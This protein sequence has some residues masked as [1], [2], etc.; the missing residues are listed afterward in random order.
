M[1][2]DD[3][4]AYVPGHFVT[5]DGLRLYTRDYQANGRAAQGVPVI[6]LAGL[7]RNSRDFQQFALMLSRDESAPRRVITIDSRGRGNSA[8]DENKSNYNIAVECGDVIAICDSLG[9][10]RA[11]FIGTSRGGLL[12]HLLAAA[13]PGLI[14]GLVLN[15]IGPVIENEGMAKIRDYLNA[16]QPIDDWDGAVAALRRIH[17][18]NF[19]ALSDRDWLDMAQAIYA[20]KDGAVAAD[21]D[22]A[23]AA[24]LLTLDLSQPLPTLW[25]QF[26]GLSNLPVLAIRGEHSELLSEATFA[27]MAQR[28]R[29]LVRLTA[30]GQGHAPSSTIPTSTPRYPPSFRKPELAARNG[31]IW[32]VAK[33]LCLPRLSL[34]KKKKPGSKAGLPRL[35]EVRPD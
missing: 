26:E 3:A 27:D 14:S 35:T 29:G 10:E 17:E 5:Q 30:A 31:R 15:D 24:Q 1:S 12:L 20:E 32:T 22:P 21:Y 25:P 2:F 8:W 34:D 23:I 19:P 18:R 6:C 33:G 11:A 9:I 13:R 28:H 16:S 7:T 4:D